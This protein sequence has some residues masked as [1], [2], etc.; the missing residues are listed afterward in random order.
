MYQN[1]CL[2]QDDDY[3]WLTVVAIAIVVGN[4]GWLTVGALTGEIEGGMVDSK[5]MDKFASFWDTL[6]VGGDLRACG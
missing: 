5:L 2:H 4:L 1:K 3:G 6:M